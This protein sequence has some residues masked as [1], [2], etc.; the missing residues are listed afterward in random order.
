MVETTGGSKSAKAV[1]KLIE[2]LKML[3]LCF[4]DLEPL[5]QSPDDRSN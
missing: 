4:S 5:F 1:Q 2:V 3:K